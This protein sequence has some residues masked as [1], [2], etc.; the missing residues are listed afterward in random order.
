MASVNVK[1]LPSI[2]NFLAELENSS[3]IVF[4]NPNN[5]PERGYYYDF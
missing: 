5:L 2:T 4:P 1:L 3:L